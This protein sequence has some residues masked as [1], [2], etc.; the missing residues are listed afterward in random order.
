MSK[1]SVIKEHYTSCGMPELPLSVDDGMPLSAQDDS[2]IADNIDKML[3]EKRSAGEDDFSSA[4]ARVFVS[5]SLYDY[6]SIQ[7]EL[8]IDLIEELMFISK[9]KSPKDLVT[10]KSVSDSI[11][12]VK[13]KN[14]A[15]IENRYYDLAREMS[16]TEMSTLSEL[17]ENE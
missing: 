16:F 17:C 14:C 13:A 9:A 1:G 15:L 10:V 12:R 5:K 11:E 6:M 3:V 4:I 8:F 7:E 2:N